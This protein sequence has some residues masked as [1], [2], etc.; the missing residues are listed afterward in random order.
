ML[1]TTSE[2]VPKGSPEAFAGEVVEDGVD[3]GVEVGQPEG[4]RVQEIRHQ[5]G[6]D[7]ADVKDDVLDVRILSCIDTLMLKMFCSG[8]LFVDVED[9]VLEKRPGA[10]SFGQ[11]QEGSCSTGLLAGW[12]SLLC[13]HSSLGVTV[14][15]CK[16]R[17][18][19]S[20]QSYL[21]VILLESIK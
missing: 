17:L 9:D 20:H 10:Q 1:R 11:F 4:H 16:Q 8:L 7:G 12:S 21:F 6:V 5:L 18:S 15:T 13:Q 2:D 3:G 14:P 19:V